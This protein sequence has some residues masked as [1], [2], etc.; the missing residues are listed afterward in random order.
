MDNVNVSTENIEIYYNDV[1]DSVYK[2]HEQSVNKIIEEKKKQQTRSSN[3]V[4]QTFRVTT[5]PI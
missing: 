4:L 3:R 2:L 1:M 5:T